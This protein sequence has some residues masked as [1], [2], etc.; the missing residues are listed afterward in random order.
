MDTFLKICDDEEDLRS[1]KDPMFETFTSVQAG[2]FCMR[3]AFA[4]NW[5]DLE[6]NIDEVNSALAYRSSRS[7]KGTQG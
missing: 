4:R 7:E 6:W 3:L 2:A 5:K 1:T